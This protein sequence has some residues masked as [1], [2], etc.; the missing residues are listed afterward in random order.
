M[1]AARGEI[2][3]NTGIICFSS[4][5]LGETVF[6]CLYNAMFKIVMFSMACGNRYRPIIQGTHFL[7]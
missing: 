1:G 6:E 5:C 4:E 3:L 2:G 7:L